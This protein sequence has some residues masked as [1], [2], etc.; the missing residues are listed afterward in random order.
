MDALVLDVCFLRCP[1]TCGDLGLGTIS[2]ANGGGPRN[3]GRHFTGGCSH[4][5]DRRSWH[6]GCQSRRFVCG[7]ADARWPTFLG[8]TFESTKTSRLADPCVLKP[9]CPLFSTSYRCRSV[10]CWR[11]VDL[12]TNARSTAHPHSRTKVVTGIAQVIYYFKTPGSRSPVDDIV[13]AST[14]PFLMCQM[15]YSRCPRYVLGSP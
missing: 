15:G 14:G 12:L 8:S 4:F 6:G 3:V 7:L 11:P 1:S 2:I 13:I 10:T 5:V 9:G